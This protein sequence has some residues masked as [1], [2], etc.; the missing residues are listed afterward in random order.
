MHG[1]REECAQERQF[2]EV[3]WWCACYEPP[4]EFHPPG[5]SGRPA[6][7]LT[8]ST[9]RGKPTYAPSGASSTAGMSEP[10]AAGGEKWPAREP[11][12]GR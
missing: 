7:F 12:A 8:R 11:E 5:V 9:T 2:L 3:G 6:G 4:A 1:R 10:L